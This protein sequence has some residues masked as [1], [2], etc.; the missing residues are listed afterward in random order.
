MCFTE[1]RPKAGSLQNA[2]LKTGDKCYL[3][4]VRG[5][6]LEVV[7]QSS[8]EKIKRCGDRHEVA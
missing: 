2:D 1:L 8:C 4:T 5:N 6:G 7:L 3:F